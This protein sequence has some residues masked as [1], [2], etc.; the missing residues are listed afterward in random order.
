MRHLPPRVRAPLGRLA[1]AVAHLNPEEFFLDVGILLVTALILRPLAPLWD[2]KGPLWTCSW[3]GLL[4]GALVSFFLPGFV[5]LTHHA[6]TQSSLP[7]GL[8]SLAAAALF[9]SA[10]GTYVG[11]PAFLLAVAFP[12]YA[13]LL[14]LIPLWFWL[15]VLGGFMAERWLGANIPPAYLVIPLGL[16]TGHILVVMAAM[17]DR[18]SAA[19]LLLALAFWTIPPLGITF[20]LRMKPLAGRGNP[21]PR[22]IWRAMRPLFLSLTFGVT[23]SLWQAMTVTTIAAVLFP[24]QPPPTAAFFWGLALGGIIPLRVLAN[25]APPWRLSNTLMGLVT[26]VGYLSYLL[27]WLRAMV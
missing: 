8:K 15:A 4:G 26:L 20:F 21:W 9:L 5:A 3:A 1:A 22:G 11:P 19:P 12:G 7:A 27:H 17:I 25:L 13:T 2:W 10:S 18:N 23:M 6:Y 24:N 16:F 14:W